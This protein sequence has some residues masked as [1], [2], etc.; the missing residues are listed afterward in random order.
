MSA[1]RWAVLILWLALAVVA[2]AADSDKKEETVK[3]PQELLAEST[4]KKS[5]SGTFRLW[6]QTI[7]DGKPLPKVIGTIAG[8]GPTHQVMVRDG[9]LMAQLAMRNGKNVVVSGTF[10]NAGETGVFL[11]AEALIESDMPLPERRKRGGL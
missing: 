6:A 7:T 5:V 8:Q 1:A 9:T 11:M 4:E 2:R 3:T 10:A